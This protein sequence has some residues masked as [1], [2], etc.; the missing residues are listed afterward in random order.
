MLRTLLCF[1]SIS[2]LMLAGC[3]GPNDP[4]SASPSTAHQAASSPAAQTSSPAATNT[5][6]SPVLDRTMT[7]LSGQ[8]VN[9]AKKYQGKVVLIVNTASKCGYTPQYAG[10]QKIYEK[11]HPQGLVVLGF[12]C[13][14]FGHQAPGDSTHIRQF[15]TQNYGVTFDMF[16]K[17]KVNGPQAA[18]LYQYLTSK[19][20]PLKDQGPIKWNFEKFLIGR[21][22]QL[23]ARY[24]SAVK[25]TSA[26]MLKAIEHQLAMNTPAG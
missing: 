15:C 9:L 19:K 4:A 3:Q 7:T 5:A 13:N 22:G 18:P 2:L 17:I 26:K 24:R 14:Q 12:P 23:I 8:Q 11:F 1:T 16:A 25:P 20:T 21:N 10:L 6:V